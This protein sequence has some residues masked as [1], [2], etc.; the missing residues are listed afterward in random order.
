MKHKFLGSVVAAALMSTSVMAEG[1]MLQRFEA[2]EKEMNALKAELAAMKAEK[3]APVVAK[4]ATVEDDDDKPAKATAGKVKIAVDKDDEKKSVSEDLEDIHDQLSTLN[5]RTNGNAIKWD[6]DFRTTVDNIDYRMADGTKK[7]NDALFSNRLWLGMNY[8]ATK[9]L[10][11]TGQL[12][13]N[14]TFGQRATT[15]TASTG[16]EGFDWISSEAA[17]DDKLRVRSAYFFYQDDEFLG[18][19]IPWT[20]SVGRRPSTEGHLINLRDGDEASSPLAHT[21]NVEFDGA[22]AKFGMEGLTGLN[23][24]YFKLC[25]GRGMSS[26][27][28]RFSSAPYSDQNATTNNIDM[29]GIIIVPY[30]DKQFSVGMQYTY[31]NN[32]I[33]SVDVTN[34]NSGLETVGGLSTAT[35]FV[36]VNGIGNKWSDFLDDSLIFVSGAMSKTDPYANKYMLG[37]TESQTGYS[38]WI[39]T[40]FPSLISDEGRWGVEFN[41][42]SQY[43]RPITYGEDTLIGSK[44]AARGNAYEVYFTEPLVK[45]ILSFQ[46]RYTYIDYDYAGSNGFFGGQPSS[47]SGSGTP[48]A[49]SNTMSNA[50]SYVDKA[51]DIRAYI[52]YK[53]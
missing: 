42:G 18:T 34:P 24:S 47:T 23:G 13:Y 38:Y 22:S 40:Q 46:L 9:H 11:F 21:I 14:K 31:A 28:P 45:N 6:V 7:T 20:V 12:A 17:Y 30:D 25:A 19:D 48:Y 39:G 1:T 52:R 49:I 33:D 35:A 2:M 44:L 3:S 15:S 41:H 51:Q 53:F 50:G 36:M 16:M 43:W 29:A 5:K 10:S 4:T 27:E 26:A 8:P 32:L 37:S